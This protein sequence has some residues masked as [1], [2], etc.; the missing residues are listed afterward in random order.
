MSVAGGAGDTHRNG[1][2]VM[3]AR[4]S[5]GARLVYKPRSLAV[6]EHF[7]QLLCW[8]NEHGAEPR[9]RLLRS[10]DRGAWGWAEF[11]DRKACEDEEEV[12]RFYQRQGA[13]AAILYALEAS[14]FHCEN[15]IAH[16]EHPML[17]DLEALFHPRMNEA[18]SSRADVIAGS[19]LGYSVLRTGLLP[20]RYWASDESAG[21]DMSGLG[22]VAGELTPHPVPQWESA[23]TDEM[24]AVRR[25]MEMQGSSNRPWLNGVEANAFDYAAD[26][27]H[28]FASTYRILLRHRQ[29]LPAVLLTFARD[30]VRVI[31]RPTQTYG[32][33]LYESFHPDMLRREDDRVA[34]FQRLRA[35]GEGA[36]QERV[37]EI[38]RAELLRGD[39]PLFTSRPGSRHLWSSTGERI[40][41]FFEEPGVALVQRRLG[42][43]SDKDLERQLWILRASIASVGSHPEARALRSAEPRSASHPVLT[44]AK[45]LEAA[46][47]I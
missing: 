4:F 9:F 3:I 43:L 15:L 13:Y 23:D 37:A 41:D 38:E 26:V 11:L 19:T 35:A 10:L 39:I 6:D 1:R 12:R 46:R 36:S 25:R 31:L 29:E 16:G 47:A 32:A 27:A 45:C 17:I 2:S 22:S 21:V 42:Q 18:A 5:T 28:G 8:L 40:P 34:L 20:Q 33:L 14:D 30:E 24:H 44:G 7:Q